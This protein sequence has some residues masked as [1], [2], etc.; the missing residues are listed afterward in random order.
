MPAITEGKLTFNFPVGW[1]A[2][3]YDDWAHY[4]NQFI[5]VCSGTKAVDVL[6]VQAGTCCWLLEIKDYRRYRRT[7]T[8][9]LAEEVAGK[10]RDTL[11]GLVS[12]QLRAN[13]ASEMAAARRA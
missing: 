5:K 6:A 10:V 2:E 11:A 12:A 9:N 7:K 1:L 13:D 4:R 8:I 3:K